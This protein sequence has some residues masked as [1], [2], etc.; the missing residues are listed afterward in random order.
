MFM[1]QAKE[2]LVIQKEC[3]IFYKIE[4]ERQEEGI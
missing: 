1:T 2:D 4:L 3:N